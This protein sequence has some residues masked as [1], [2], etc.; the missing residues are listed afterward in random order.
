MLAPKN[1]L[2]RAVLPLV[3]P[4]PKSASVAPEEGRTLVSRSALAL[5][6]AHAF[7][8][9]GVP[10]LQ[11]HGPAPEKVWQQLQ[12]QC[13]A[14]SA[15]LAAVAVRDL[16]TNLAGH[17]ML[18]LLNPFRVGDQVSFRHG[19]QLIEGTIIRRGL[20]YTT[21]QTRDSTPYY[22]P[23][24]AFLSASVSNLSR[25]PYQY[26]E[27]QLALPLSLADNATAITKAIRSRL[28]RLPG[29]ASTKPVTVSVTALGPTS[30]TLHAS[31]YLR[32]DDRHTA[33]ELQQAFL[34]RLLSAAREQGAAL[35]PSPATTLQAQ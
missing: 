19:G 22:V 27:A 17:T 8:A 4:A 6:V 26:C 24:S 35:L 28:R 9:Y 10:A 31:C 30:L 34:L 25:M 12:E 20:Y 7:F 2:A 1:A 18:Q 3:K 29:V 13:G 11:E 32:R 21:V 5:L 15:G 14:V 23:N 33:R 16:A